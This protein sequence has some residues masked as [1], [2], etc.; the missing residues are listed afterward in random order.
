M[1][2]LYVS[3]LDGTL[4]NREDRLSPYTI[5]VLQ[6]VQQREDVYF[7][8]ATARSHVTAAQVTQGLTV[9]LPVIVYNGAFIIESGTGRV[10]DSCGF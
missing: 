10:L 1:P 4:L 6:E 5:R 7:S 9:A 2:T 3:D 8:Y